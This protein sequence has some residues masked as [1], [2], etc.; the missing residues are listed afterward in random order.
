M[1]ATTAIRNY[2]NKDNED[3]ATVS[4]IKQ[5]KDTCSK[6]EWKDFGRQSCELLGEPFEE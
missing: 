4:E 5:F 2:I 1:K 6:E 3:K